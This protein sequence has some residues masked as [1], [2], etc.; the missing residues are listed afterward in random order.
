MDY[1]DRPKFCDMRGMLSFYTLWLLGWNS[2]CGEEISDIIARKKGEKPNPGTIYPAL[3]KLK[4]AG[5]I[6][7]TR[8]GREIRYSITEEGRAELH[9]SARYFLGVY[10]EVFKYYS[11]IY[12]AKLDLR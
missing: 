8:R 5:L 2:M 3:K 7:P 9:R 11:E 6:K 1:L 10:G 12:S 4:E